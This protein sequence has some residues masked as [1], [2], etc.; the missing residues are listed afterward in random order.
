MIDYCLKNNKENFININLVPEIERRIKFSD[1][2]DVRIFKNI[3]HSLFQSDNDFKK[4]LYH[5]EEYDEIYFPTKQLCENIQKRDNILWRKVIQYWF[6]EKPCLKRLE[7]ICSIINYLGNRSDINFLSK[8]I[9]KNSFNV[10]ANNLVVS[11][12]FKLKRR[13]LK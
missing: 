4:K 10:Q 7:I 6:N 9:K 11:T 1:K 8:S 5:L 2:N 3:K 12:I 13:S